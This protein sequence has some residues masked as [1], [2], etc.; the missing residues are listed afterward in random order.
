MRLVA[1]EILKLRRR[2]A[3][4]IWSALLTVGPTLVAYA[5]LL[6]LHATNPDKHVCSEKCFVQGAADGTCTDGP[7]GS[8]ATTDER[9]FSVSI[10]GNG[11]CYIPDA[12]CI[13][14]GTCD[15]GR[16]CEG[17]GYCAPFAVE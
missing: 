5:V 7:D 3:L 15:S 14:D 9:N 4:M 17:Q 1:A 8:G 6:S 10:C 11:R 2:R 12:S 16:R 13:D